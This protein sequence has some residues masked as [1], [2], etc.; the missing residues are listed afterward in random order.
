MST[1]RSPSVPT[2]IGNSISSPSKIN[3]ATSVIAESLFV[4]MLMRT[5]S[6]VDRT[7]A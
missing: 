3:F 2:T 7:A 6:N 4:T 5:T 1:A